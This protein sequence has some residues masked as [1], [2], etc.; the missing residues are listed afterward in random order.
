MVLASKSALLIFSLIVCIVILNNSKAHAEN[1]LITFKLFFFN[2]ISNSY[3]LFFELLCILINGKTFPGAIELN[4]TFNVLYYIGNIL[5]AICWALYANYKVYNK[6]DKL[7]KLFYVLIPFV[8]INVI[9]S[10]ACPF[11]KLYF[12]IGTQNLYHREMFA[13]PLLLFSYILMF[14]TFIIIL[15]NQT[16][17][18]KGES[19]PLL[20]YTIPPFICSVFQ[21]LFY[22]ISIIWPSITISLLIIYL[23][24]QNYRLNTDYLTGLFNRRQLEAFISAKINSTSNK[25]SGILID[26]DNFKIINDKFGH[27]IGDEALKTVAT[28][29]KET[30]SRN[31]FVARYGGDEFVIIMNTKNIE[32]LKRAVAKL[33]F[34]IQKANESGKY[35]YPLSLSMGYQVYNEDLSIST[36]EFLRE[37]DILMYESKKNKLKKHT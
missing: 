21:G 16:R 35:Q 3:M 13:A 32:K 29:I 4:Y 20:F 8:L 37:I 18:P 1:Q 33:H 5:P 9:I 27:T 31:D 23:N 17:L 25:F 28:I 19:G 26:V 11:A 6:E 10:A 24:L 2:L 30:L 7:L 12:T 15:K 14:Y 34:A 36:E 22:D